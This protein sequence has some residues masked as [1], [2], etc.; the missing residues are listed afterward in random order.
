MRKIHQCLYHLRCLKDFKLPSK[1]LRS[2]YICTTESILTGSITSWFWEEHHAGQAALQ[3]SVRSV[4]IITELP[5]LQSVYSQWC[6]TK[7]RKI[8]KDLSHPTNR[9][10]SLLWW[11]SESFFPFVIQATSTTLWTRIGIF[12]TFLHNKQT[13]KQIDE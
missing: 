10:F 4:E 2:F 11:K 6:W 8:F 1:V 9:L 12:W 5:D 3:R 7:A 13:N